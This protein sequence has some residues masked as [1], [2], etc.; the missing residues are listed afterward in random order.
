MRR[1]LLRDNRLH[2][3]WRVTLYL[4]VHFVG[5]ILIA[6]GLT[7][8]W[9]ILQAARGA[10]LDA[11]AAQVASDSSSPALLLASGLI[12]LG[13]ALAL[14][15][16]CLR[17]IDGVPFAALGFRRSLA[18]RDT[19]LGLAAGGVSMLTVLGLF[20][21]FGW[22]RVAAVTAPRADTG[23]A[24]FVAL[25]AAAASEEVVFRGYV[26]RALAEWRGAAFALGVSSILFALAHLGNPGLTPL[27]L[28]N[29]A[30]AGVAFGLALQL[31]GRLWLPIAYH[32]AWNY[33]QG[34]LFGLPVSGLALPA[35][36][37]VTLAGPTLWTGGAFGPEGGLIV[38]LILISSLFLL[39]RLKPR[40][41]SSAGI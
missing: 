31:T 16:L 17:W 8:L 41:A 28:T 35:F 36:L 14:A 27:A 22:M 10:D 18:G 39:L 24:V 7:V 26:L 20:L 33:F 1:F 32:F 9:L 4:A 23:L 15:G 29:I 5:V 25:A 11:L 19:L 34:P 38:S 13:W 12:S 30:L 37:R 40:R 6:A 3:F 21:A 2:P